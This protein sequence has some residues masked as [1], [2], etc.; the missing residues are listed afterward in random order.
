M[1]T[2]TGKL[3]FSIFLV[4]VCLCQPA[5]SQL[6]AR[7]LFYHEKPDHDKLPTAAQVR[8]AVRSSAKPAASA[9]AARTPQPTA[10]EAAKRPDSD[11]GGSIVMNVALKVP[12]VQNLG[13]RYN[14]LLVNTETGK[15]APVDP[16]RVFQPKECLALE[17]QSNRSGYL[18]VFEQ[19]SSG[20]W[21][22]MFPT[23]ELPDESNVIRS[24][25]TVRI[26]ARDCFEVSGDP[27]V[28]RV[29]VVL[30][31]NV[32]DYYDLSESVKG[33]QQPGSQEPKAAPAKPTSSAPLLMASD[34]LG[35]QIAKMR[36]ALR[37]RD[38]TLKK[39]SQP[40]SADEPANSVYIVNTSASS[41]D[42]VVAEIHINHR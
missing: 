2:R 29:F 14:V 1:F 7:E 33:D 20:K 3:L 35:A 12:P 37:G 27:G 19:A 42:R 28:D 41:S 31:R 18:Y 8:A 38:L 16:E 34:R 26:P 22:P 15:A 9:K 36:E 21:S 10:T 40:E 11:R 13:L 25:T 39:I 24:R 6:S 5:P 17:F 23:P 4:K 32:E 30:S